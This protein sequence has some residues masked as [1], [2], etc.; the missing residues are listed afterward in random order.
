MSDHKTQFQNHLKE[1]IKTKMSGIYQ[2]EKRKKKKKKKKKKIKMKNKN[3]MKRNS[4]N[5]FQ[6]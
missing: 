2:N 5:H 4:L 3:K 6:Q 1:L